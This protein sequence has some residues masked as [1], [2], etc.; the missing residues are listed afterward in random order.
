MQK[1][2]AE[3]AKQIQALQA[4]QALPA[5]LDAGVL[6]ATAVV[7]ERPETFI[8][9]KQ[10]PSPKQKLAPRPDNASL[11]PTLP[12]FWTIP[13]T[14]MLLRFGGDAIGVFL[15]TSKLM[16]ATTWF[17]TSSIPVSGQ[18][19]FDSPYQVTGTAN[20]SDLNFEFRVPTPAGLLRVVYRNDFA[21][22]DSSAFTYDLKDFYVQVANFL[23]GVTETV[24]ADVDA[25]PST[26]DYAGTNSEVSYRHLQVRYVL[27]LAR[28]AHADVLLNLALESPSSQ[29]PASAGT[30]RSVAPD[31]TA[32][33]RLEGRLG[34]LQL[35]TLLRGIGSQTPSGQSQ[36][37]LGWGLSLSGNLNLWGGDFLSFQVA[38]GQGAAAYFNDTG[39][40]GL[41]A[42][43]NTAGHLTALSIF[44]A[45]LGITHTWAAQWNSTASYGYLVMDTA[46]YA[47]SVGSSGFHRSQ[48]ASLNLVFRPSKPLLLGVEGL[49][50]Y[51]QTVSGASGHA[52]RGQMNFQFTF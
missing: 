44:G 26:L 15:V 32:S 1:A 20:Q 34:H 36:T 29:I 8:I 3:Q 30:P 9:D 27:K 4:Q 12:G 31:G 43:D 6:P 28:S 21:Q 18:P 23:L 37:V 7:E 19:F 40:L 13:G 42:A 39:G 2:L 50:G 45:F 24:F 35:A 38:G 22:P 46:P 10:A 41:D 14:R 52:W 16:G 47:A 48:Y 17:V 5:P 51:H 11:T 49:W 33:L 25:Q